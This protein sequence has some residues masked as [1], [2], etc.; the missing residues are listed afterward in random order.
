METLNVN[1]DAFKTAFPTADNV[2]S[3]TSTQWID[4]SSKR[5]VDLYAVKSGY[6]MQCSVLES[7][8]EGY[9]LLNNAE[10]GDGVTQNAISNA[11]AVGI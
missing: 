10:M 5:V 6:L 3:V 8:L 2:H 9:E 11:I 1:F 7:E 4:A